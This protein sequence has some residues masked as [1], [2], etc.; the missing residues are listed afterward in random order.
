MAKNYV[1]SLGDVVRL[2]QPYRPKGW[3][4]QKPIDWKGF[5]FGIVAEFGSDEKISLFLYDAEGQLFLT[6]TLAQQALVIPTYVEFDVGEL[7][8]YEIV[9]ESGYGNLS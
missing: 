3:S 8:R 5:E 7:V 2:K 6:P 4:E 9:S 1:L